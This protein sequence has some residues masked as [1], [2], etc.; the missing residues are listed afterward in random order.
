MNF[1]YAVPCIQM[2]S[3]YQQLSSSE[4]RVLLSQRKLRTKG[5]KE[6]CIRRLISDD[7]PIVRNYSTFSV[8]E[9]K[10]MLKYRNLPTSGNKQLL[11]ARLEKNKPCLFP[12]HI[13]LIDTLILFYMSDGSSSRISTINVYTYKLWRSEYYWKLRYSRAYE[14]IPI[15]VGVTFHT[16]YALAQCTDQVEQMEVAVRLN[17]AP[18]VLYI[19]GRTTMTELEIVQ[20][21][22]RTNK[23]PIWTNYNSCMDGRAMKLAIKYRKYNVFR[24]LWFTYGFSQKGYF[25]KKQFHVE[26]SHMY[27]WCVENEDMELLI[28]ITKAVSVR[29]MPQYSDEVNCARYVLQFDHNTIEFC[30]TGKVIPFALRYITK[31]CDLP[32]FT[33][34]F[35]VTIAQQAPN[36][37]YHHYY[38]IQSALS[39]SNKSAADEF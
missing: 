13:D 32:Y 12:T 26:Y 3:R 38:E 7:H 37:Y 17:D 15:P 5:T 31:V 10:A 11:A 22:Q 28:H 6:E 35:M 4:L 34:T 25:T 18:L 23:F 27:L 20:S 14:N 21:G 29:Y 36:W 8:D 39:Y 24:A 19:I 9:L 16:A 2:Q 30:D 33:P 1:Y